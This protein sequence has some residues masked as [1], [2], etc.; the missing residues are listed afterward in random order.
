MKNTSESNDV[1]HSA[2]TPKFIRIPTAVSLTGISRS[3]LYEIIGAGKIA[4]V[5]LRDEG[6][7]KATRLVSYDSLMRYLEVRMVG[8]EN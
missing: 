1:H 7:T 6:Q 8:G 2:L 3:K 4:S 5:S